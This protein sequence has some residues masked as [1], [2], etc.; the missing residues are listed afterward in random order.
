MKISK[1]EFNCNLSILKSTTSFPFF[2]TSALFSSK[3]LKE[4]SNSTGSH[5]DQA[6]G[7]MTRKQKA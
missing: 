4:E 1:P 2:F 3:Q 6:L 7:S 5:T